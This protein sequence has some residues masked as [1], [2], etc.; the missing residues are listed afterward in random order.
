MKKEKIIIVEGPQGAGKTTITDYLRNTLPYTNL[1]RL[2]GI[3]DS[4]KSGL[5]KVNRYYE[6][7]LDYMKELENIN[8][9]LLFDRTF[10]SEEAY[11]RLGFK[12]YSFTENYNKFLKKLDNLDFDIYYFNLYLDDE[13]EFEKRLNR[14]GKA[15]IK[16]AKFN[17]ENS[18]KQQN[19]YKEL[20]KEIEEKTKNIKVINFNSNRELSEIFK[21][22]DEIIDNKEHK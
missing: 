14:E 3:S 8:I 1:Y 17:V 2:S 15:E 11:C 9:N 18:V 12:E 6:T 13:S 20:A 4:T 16:Y 19:M 7:L 10:F 22:I 5:E 21:E